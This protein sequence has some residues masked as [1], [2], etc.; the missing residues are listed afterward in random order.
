MKDNIGSGYVLTATQAIMALRPM[1][2]RPAEILLEEGE[3]E[4]LLDYLEKNLP[5]E[6]PRPEEVFALGDEDSSD[7]LASGETY[8]RWAEEDLYERVEK[9]GTKALRN[10]LG[11]VPEP[12]HWNIWG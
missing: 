6:I 5:P 8:V 7:D 2:R 10:S 11:I 4:G 12:C 1:D 9:E 3:K